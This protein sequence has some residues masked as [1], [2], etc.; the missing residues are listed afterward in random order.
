[1]TKDT[2]S[3]NLLRDRR[4]S[5][6][7]QFLKWALTVGRFL[8]IVTE[9]T[10][11]VMFLYRFSLDRQLIDLHDKIKQEGVIVSYLQENETAYRNLQ[12]RIAFAKKLHTTYQQTPTIFQYVV[13]AA[14]NTVTFNNVAISHKDIVIDATT[15][16]VP[17]LTAFVNAIKTQENIATVSLNKVENRTSNATITF[18]M[19]ATL[20]QSSKQ[21]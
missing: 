8:V 2:Y 10:A 15:S 6:G 12:D 9:T 11:L 4:K 20:K 19:T 16:S 14:G 17:A 1:M 3:V 7:E 5:F 21:L 18:S 13:D